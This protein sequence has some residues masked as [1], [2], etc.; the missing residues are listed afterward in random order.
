MGSALALLSLLG[1]CGLLPPAATLAQ[2][3]R[4][5]L[6]VLSL[7]AGAVLLPPDTAQAQTTTVW[8]A[9][10]TVDQFSAFSSIYRGCGGNVADSCATGLNTDDFTYGGTTFHIQSLN[11]VTGSRGNQIFLSLDSAIPSAIRTNGRLTL[12]TTTLNPSF[13]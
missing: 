12:G 13:G 8:T 6:G 1:C 11:Q 5:A 10:L 3:S 9:T 4:W 7:L 2:R